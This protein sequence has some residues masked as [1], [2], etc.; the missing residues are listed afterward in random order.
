MK[1]MEA[2][3]VQGGEALEDKERDIAQAKR[4]LQLKLNEEQEKQK[5]LIEEKQRQEQE[6]LEKDA[7]YNSL[8][9]EV[10]A[11]R[12]IIK[13]LRQK[14][15]QADSELKDAQRDLAGDREDLLNTIRD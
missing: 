9:E 3:L 6:L 15:K 2:K 4:E 1:Q 8:Q 10:E 5:N 11:Q 13:K 12:N 7:K 14:Y